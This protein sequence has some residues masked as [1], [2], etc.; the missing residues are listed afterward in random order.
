MFCEIWALHDFGEVR[1]PVVF[2]PGP[3]R[4]T[5]IADRIGELSNSPNR[6]NSELPANWALRQIP[7]Q[8]QIFLTR[9]RLR[10]ERC[11]SSAPERASP[12]VHQFD[13]RTPLRIKPQKSNFDT[14]CVN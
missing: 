1:L 3:L 5:G 11:F 13:D 8:S 2:Q 4:K 6:R 7:A 10:E 9:L 12:F 14:L